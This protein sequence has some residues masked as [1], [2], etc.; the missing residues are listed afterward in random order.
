MMGGP[1]MGMMG[2]GGMMGG[3]EMGMMGH[4][5]ANSGNPWN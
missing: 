2:H 1:E 3:P 4:G 5:E